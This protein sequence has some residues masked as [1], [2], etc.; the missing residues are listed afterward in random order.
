MT[1]ALVGSLTT[2]SGDG[3]QGPGVS[4]RGQGPGGWL[5]TVDCGRG[6]SGSDSLVVEGGF[7]GDASIQGPQPPVFS[8]PSA[9]TR[10]RCAGM[11]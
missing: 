4:L 5:S 1:T 11:T 2:V 10:A 7:P 9:A 6:S 8:P 3:G